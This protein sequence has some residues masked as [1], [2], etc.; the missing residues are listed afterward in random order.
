MGRIDDVVGG[1]LEKSVR[2]HH[3]NRLSKLGHADVFSADD[4]RTWVPGARAATTGNDVEVLI[5]GE[6]AFASIYDALRAAHS[7]VHIAGWHLTTVFWLRREP[8]TPTL[9]EILVDLAQRVDV[10]VLLWAGP[11]LPIFQPTRSMMK[12]VQQ[13]L[14]RGSSVRCELDARERTMHCHHE[15]VIVI[16][17]E[18]AFVGGIDLSDL[19]GDR[20][21]L[22]AHPPRGATGWH[23]VS[24]RLRGPVVADVADHFRDRWQEVAHERLPAPVRQPEA[25]SVAVQLLR[26]VPERTYGFARRGEFSIADAYLHGLASARRFIYL[27]NQFLW[28]AEIAE[29]LIEKLRN[30]PAPDFRI[31]IVLPARPSN[32]ADTTRGQLGR[33]VAADN[34]AGRLLAATVNAH[35]DGTIDPLY[36]HAKVAVV[37]DRWL[38]IGSANLNEHS[39]FNDT[40]VNVLTLDPTLA[41]RTRLRLWA[42]HL[43]LGMDVIDGDPTNVIDRYWK[44]VAEEQL[45]RTRTG[46]PQNRRVMTL[47]AVSRRSERLAGPAR[48]LLVDG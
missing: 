30:P 42:E 24:T 22:S 39:L 20:W 47:P 35:A 46:R 45:A 48:G 10:R 8:G 38:T 9:R 28:S 15:K 1:A 23:D 17:D 25:G 26:T 21:D 13:E 44:P 31:V 27:E 14:T 34:G 36:V 4:S 6:A 19:S 3:R 7:H 5:D 37:D 41:R 18:L 32:G 29:L 33:L 2:R 12:Q 43:E 40:E 11:P 16:D